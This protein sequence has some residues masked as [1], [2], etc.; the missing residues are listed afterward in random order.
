MNEVVKRG[1]GQREGKSTKVVKSRGRPF[2]FV[3]FCPEPV[4]APD[5]LGAGAMWREERTKE[6][7]GE[8]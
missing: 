6:N 2:T 1:V 8:R 7:K 5:C 4:E 3:G